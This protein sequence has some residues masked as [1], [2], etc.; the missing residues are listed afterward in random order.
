MVCPNNAKTCKEK[1]KVPKL[2]CPNGAETCPD[3]D[4]IEVRY[5]FRSPL[6]APFVSFTHSS[7]RFAVFPESFTGGAVTWFKHVPID[8]RVRTYSE[9]TRWHE[10]GFDI[11]KDGA[12]DVLKVQDTTSLIPIGLESVHPWVDVAASSFSTAIRRRCP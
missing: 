12:D 4:K 9:Q 11:N 7:K 5:K 1:E 3:E 2:V 8:K 6:A 10:E